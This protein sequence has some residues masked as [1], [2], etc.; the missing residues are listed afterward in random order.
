MTRTLI[1]HCGPMKTGST[2]IQDTLEIN[3]KKLLNSGISY[4]HIRAKTLLHDLEKA[5]SREKNS[6]NKIILLSS[7]FFCQTNPKSLQQ[8]LQPFKGNCH[9]ILVS[10]PLSEIYPSLYLQNLKGSSRRITSFKYFLDRQ[11]ISDLAPEKKL[12]GQLMN[13]PA[14]DARL[15]AAGCRTHWIKYSRKNLLLAFSTSLEK[16]I[17]IPL[18]YLVGT[19]TRKPEGLSPRRSLRMELAGIARAINYLNRLNLLSDHLREILLIILLN[20]SDLLNQT[21]RNRPSLNR[22]QVERCNAVDRTTNEPFLKS[23]RFGILKEQQ[24]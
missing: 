7:E 5:I 6:K 24:H 10:R 15:S 9:A 18:D 17:G 14:L 16:I 2:A 22:R 13:F 1:L 8:I 3:K 23:H 12:G 21:L 4:Y 11:I 19:K 20:T